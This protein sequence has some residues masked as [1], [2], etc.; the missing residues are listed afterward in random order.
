MLDLTS[1]SLTVQKLLPRFTFLLQQSDRQ[2]DRQTVTG[3]KL[4]APDFNSGGHKN[5]YPQ[6]DSNPQLY[7]FIVSFQL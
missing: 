2:S 3:Q 4:D 1:L 6:L 7:V 5:S